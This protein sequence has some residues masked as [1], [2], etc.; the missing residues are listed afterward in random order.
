[1]ADRG[2]RLG[3][4]LLPATATAFPGTP[5]VVPAGRCNLVYVHAVNVDTS[6]RL[7]RIAIGTDADGTRIF[8]DAEVFPGI[9][10]S[11]K[12]M[13]PLESGEGFEVSADVANKITLTLNVV[14]N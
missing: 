12:V 5:Y 8:H 3:P 14:E 7:L 9:P 1:M 4:E 10:L 13:I 6:N 2:R 11:Y